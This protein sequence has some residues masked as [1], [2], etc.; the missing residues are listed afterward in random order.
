MDTE[1]EGQ[2]QANRPKERPTDRQ[3]SQTDPNLPARRQARIQ[4]AREKYTDKCRPTNRQTDRQTDK[5]NIQTCRQ[6]IFSRLR[7]KSIAPKEFHLRERILEKRRHKWKFEEL[8]SKRKKLMM[9]ERALET[10]LH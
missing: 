4:P 1:S 8:I 5:K 6:T 3:A 2:R 9:V 7:L 10:Q